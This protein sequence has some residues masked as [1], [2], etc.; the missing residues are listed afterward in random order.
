MRGFH[1]KMPC[2]S[3]GLADFQTAVRNSIVSNSRWPVPSGDIPVLWSPRALAKLF[4]QFLRAFEGDMVLGNLSFLTS[5]PFPLELPFQVEDSPDPANIPCDHEGSPTRQVTL[6]NEGRPKALACNNSIAEQLAVSS[7]G[8]CRRE[9]F[10]ST[11]TV[12]FWN[13][14]IRGIRETATSMRLSTGV[15]RA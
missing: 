8:H 3:E 10:Q 5:L 13:P 6:F 11:P 14:R 2:R 15:L 1:R 9:S 4:L 12:G 7:T